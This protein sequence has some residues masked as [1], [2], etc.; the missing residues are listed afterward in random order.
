MPVH[1]NYKSCGNGFD[2]FS[3][4][5]WLG[6]KPKVL[7]QETS[8]NNLVLKDIQLFHYPPYLSNSATSN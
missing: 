4:R 8:Y 7:L 6:R 3:L 5:W 2:N 1:N